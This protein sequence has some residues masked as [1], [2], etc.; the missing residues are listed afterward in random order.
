MSTVN[1]QITFTSDD[2]K[3]GGTLSFEKQD[4]QMDIQAVQAMYRANVEMVLKEGKTKEG[5][6]S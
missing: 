3:S 2:G 1:I 5:A 6:E 4:V